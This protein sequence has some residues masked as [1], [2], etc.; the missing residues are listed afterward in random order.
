M[1]FKSFILGVLLLLLISSTTYAHSG[2]NYVEYIG[3][4]IRISSNILQF[5]DSN[6]NISGIL[7]ADGTF[8]STYPTNFNYLTTTNL[9]VTNILFPDGTV[10]TTA[11][12]NNISTY[13]LI[14]TNVLTTLHFT[15]TNDFY[16]TNS[17]VAKN[18]ILQRGYLFIDGTNMVPWTLDQWATFTLYSNTNYLYESVLAEY[19]DKRLTTTRVHTNNVLVGSKT[20]IVTN[21]TIFNVNDPVMICYTNGLYQFNQITDK[22]GNTVY[23]R[24]GI[25]YEIPSNSTN[26]TI[27]TTFVIGNLNLFDNTNETNLYGRLF[28]DCT[29]VYTGNFKIQYSERN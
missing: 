12:T 25:K 27:S 16:F 7:F 9:A 11:P 15:S 17:A 23:L 19:K 29:N 21:A 22:I 24:D 10:L 13:N 14:T 5:V 1:S 18:Y 4:G 6:P 3:R 26:N 28:L 8:L 20:V 2:S